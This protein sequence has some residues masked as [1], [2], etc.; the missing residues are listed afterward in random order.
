MKSATEPKPRT[1][2]D[3]A[4]N[5]KGAAGKSAI[6]LKIRD[7]GEMTEYEAV[8][9]RS[10]GETLKISGSTYCDTKECITQILKRAL[11]GKRDL[12]PTAEKAV[13]HLI[14]YLLT[15]IKQL[16]S[17]KASATIWVGIGAEDDLG[18]SVSLY[19]L[20]AGEAEDEEEYVGWVAEITAMFSGYDGA[21]AVDGFHQFKKELTLGRHLGDDAVK[22]LTEE[23][24]K[25]AKMA[26]NVSPD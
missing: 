2:K 3:K 19:R 20:D 10:G 12:P 13:E 18:L 15:S 23:L 26:Y 1:Q 5:M 16:H 9:K 4:K 22:R 8:V 6:R 7:A 14:N 11:T 25:V 24:M 21:A 17:G